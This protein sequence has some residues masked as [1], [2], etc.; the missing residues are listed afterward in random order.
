MCYNFSWVNRGRKINYCGFD[1]GKSIKN[2]ACEDVGERVGEWQGA[3][4]PSFIWR[5][6]GYNWTL[7]IAGL[8][9]KYAENFRNDKW[10]K[11]A[12]NSKIS[13]SVNHFFIWNLFILISNHD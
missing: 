7:K 11:P 4:L 9:C 8:I 1:Q 6:G 5:R 12:S 13:E 3:V 10:L 2:R